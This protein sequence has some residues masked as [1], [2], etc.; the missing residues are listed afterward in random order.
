MQHGG[1]VKLLGLEMR[2]VAT[3]HPQDLAPACHVEG[4]L[5]QA[6]VDNNRPYA[7]CTIRHSS[8]ETSHGEERHKPQ[9]Q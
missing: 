3:M 2:G 4:L 9:L 8:D 5:L 6:H 7:Q 1:I